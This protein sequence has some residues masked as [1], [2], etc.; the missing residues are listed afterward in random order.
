MKY[1]FI[2]RI[3]F[4]ILLFFLLKPYLLG[5]GVDADSIFEYDP[6]AKEFYENFDHS[7]LDNIPDWDEIISYKNLGWIDLTL[8]VYYS[9]TDK[10][11]SPCI[12][13]FH[14][15][16]WKTRAINQFKQYAYYFSER[17]YTAMSVKYRVFDDSPDVIPCDEIKDAKSA[18]RYVRSHAES[19]GIYPDKIIVGG[20]SSGGHLATA[21]A[22]I[23]TC[24]EDDE[25]NAFSCLPD[26]LML[27][28]PLV[29]LS[30]NGWLAG[31]DYLGDDW[32][33]LS[34]IHHIDINCR[35]IPSIIL[36][37]SSDH[38][39][40]IKNMIHWDNIYHSLNGYSQL[41]VFDGRGHGFSNYNETKSGEGHRD[42]IYSLYF[43]EA[44]LLQTGYCSNCIAAGKQPDHI[45]KIAIYP[46]P[47]SNNLNIISNLMIDKIF[48]FSL[49]GKIE[50]TIKVNNTSRSIDMSG[51][52]EGLKLFRIIYT[53]GESYTKFILKQF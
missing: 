30:E 17:G 13:F 32:M 43:M 53:N 34:S 29:D 11:K 40:P 50:R 35:S 2:Y 48:V 1:Q 20:M 37:G 25:N 22:F 36:S 9:K 5:Q 41:F 31:H 8:S 7:S 23:D 21:T 51:F 39:T 46:N 14:G 33:T 26:A 4:S 16:S 28:N 38:T 12:I 24:V 18:I 27:Q 52:S 44:F 3:I 47:V 19:L 49:S 10:E 45:N 15:G 42:F 6:V